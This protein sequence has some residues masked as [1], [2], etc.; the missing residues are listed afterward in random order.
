MTTRP[1]QSA[2]EPIRI[3]FPMELRVGDRYTDDDGEWEMVEAPSTRTG[4]RPSTRASA[5]RAGR[6]R[7][8]R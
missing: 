8:G 6:R 2:P 1:R 4:A 7:S 5:T 3:V